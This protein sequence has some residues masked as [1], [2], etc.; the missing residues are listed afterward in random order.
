MLCK[1]KGHDR[2]IGKSRLEMRQV[3]RFRN[4]VHILE[5]SMCALKFEDMLCKKKDLFAVLL[6][7]SCK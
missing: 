7:L 6:N 3:D 4:F 2:I 5:S 1:I